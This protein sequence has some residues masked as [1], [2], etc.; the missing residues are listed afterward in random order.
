MAVLTIGDDC[1][2]FNWESNDLA[3]M[4]DPNR[5]IQFGLTGG[6][7]ITAADPHGLEVVIK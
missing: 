1:K 6:S 4:E 7:R 3:S 5:T 2:S